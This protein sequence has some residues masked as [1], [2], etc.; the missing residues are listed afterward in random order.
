MPGIRN[1]NR[2]GEREKRRQ[3]LFA[4]NLESDEWALTSLRPSKSTRCYQFDVQ[5]EATSTARSSSSSHAAPHLLAAAVEQQALSPIP[6]AMDFHNVLD[7]GSA[8]GFIPSEHVRSVSL[9]I[10]AGF[11]P[12]ILSY[13]GNSGP[14][15]Q[16]RRFKLEK[17]RRYLAKQLQYPTD[18]PAEPTQG[19]VFAYV[20]ERK[21]Y[22]D[23]YRAGGKAEQLQRF[24]TDILL[25]D[26]SSICNE[27]EAW[28]YVAYQVKDQKFVHVVEQLVED[29]RCGI[30]S[31]KL[32]ITRENRQT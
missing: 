19:K 5:T 30:L 6:I 10:S 27:A 18:C 29:H 14:D 21:L 9:L 26:N 17:A 22:S 15:S 31:D 12:W 25:D 20:C 4:A 3:R 11:V 13:I 8:D 28:G 32:R 24:G 2:G 7:G 16:R 23:R 1:G